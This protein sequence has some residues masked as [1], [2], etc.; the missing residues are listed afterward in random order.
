MDAGL[1]AELKRRGLIRPGA[2]RPKPARGPAELLVLCEAGVL[3]G[4]LSVA[5]D[6]QPDEAVGALCALI[7]GEAPRLRILDV[8]KKPFEL[9]IQWEG[10]EER[11]EVPDVPALVHNLN[12]LL[13]DDD[14]AR[15]LAVL[16]EWQDA[17]QLWGI[18]KPALREL[19]GKRYFQ[20]LNERDLESLAH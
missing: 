15:A 1:Y 18:P 19:L 2:Q 10:Q 20:P 4:G 11:W 16:G 13:R 14:S 3:L 17:L 9:L 5:L 12:D 6:V 8:R 7:G